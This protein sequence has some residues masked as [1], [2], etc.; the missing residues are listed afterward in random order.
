MIELGE[1]SYKT[2]QIV[3]KVKGTSEAPIVIR[4]NNATFDG[5]IDITN[6]WTKHSGNIYKT[7]INE[8]IWQLF[9]GNEKAGQF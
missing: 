8:N 5:T 2:A 6:E 1:G 7:Q 9:V 3:D 4:G